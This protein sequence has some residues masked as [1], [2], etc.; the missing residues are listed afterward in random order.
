MPVDTRS[1]ELLEKPS[2]DADT[3]QCNRGRVEA[4]LTQGALADFPVSF[5]SR[6]LR[7]VMERRAGPGAPTQSTQERERE[8]GR[9]GG[10][11]PPPHPLLLPLPSRPSAW[12]IFPP[13][14]FLTPSSSESGGHSSNVCAF[15]SSR[16]SAVWCHI[17]VYKC[18]C[19]LH[20]CLPL[21]VMCVW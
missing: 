3:N 20:A 11:P 18:W 9:E 21:A 17:N 14:L 13:P 10:P 12:R 2:M 15:V 16:S 19:R 7:L 8:G 1:A 6:T 4:L 5:C